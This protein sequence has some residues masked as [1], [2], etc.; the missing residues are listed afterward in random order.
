[1]RVFYYIYPHFWHTESRVVGKKVWV[2]IPTLWVKNMAKWTKVNR[3]ISGIKRIEVNELSGEYRVKLNYRYTDPFGNKKY[4]LM[5]FHY[6]KR[7]QKMTPEF[8]FLLQK[9]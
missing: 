5:P 7:K 2:N 9:V 6:S 4:I 1:M 3:K 8:F